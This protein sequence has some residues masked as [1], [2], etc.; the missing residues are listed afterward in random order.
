MTSSATSGRHFPNFEEKNGQKRRLRR[1][2]VEFQWCGILPAPPNGGLLVTNTLGIS[3]DSSF[4]LPGLL[5]VDIADDRSRWATII[6]Q[7]T[8][9]Y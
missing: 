7:A 5:R 8:F 6:N 2:L 9:V 3:T 4:Y 1:L